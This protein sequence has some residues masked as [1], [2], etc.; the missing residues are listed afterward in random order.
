MLGRI[1][2]RPGRFTGLIMVT[3]E[4]FVAAL[5]SLAVLVASAFFWVMTD[6]RSLRK[7]NKEDNRLLREQMRADYQS[8]REEL[9]GDLQSLRKEM[10]EDNQALR[11][12]M[13]ETNRALREEMREDN[14]A[15][16]EEM[17]EDNRALREEMLAAIR[18]ESEAR[19]AD[20]QRILDAIYY[21]RHDPDGSVVFLPPTQQAAD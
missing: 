21:H 6:I 17:R 3:M 10:R 7:D 11:E 5:S 15:L 2:V 12:E 4:V 13:R 20:T 9:R 8:F 16:R 14:R 18:T 19:R 1:V